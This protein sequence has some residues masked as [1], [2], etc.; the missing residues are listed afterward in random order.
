VGREDALHFAERPRGRSW[1]ERVAAP[2][3]GIGNGWK[4]GTCAEHPELIHLLPKDRRVRLAQ[5]PA[6]CPLGCAFMKDRVVG[7]LPVHLGRTLRAAEMRGDRVVL[8]FADQTGKRHMMRAD[9]VVFATGYR[10]DLGS[11]G[12]LKPDLV[13]QMRLVDQSP[14]LSRNYESSLP[15]L[16]FIGPAATNSFGPVSRF[17]YGTAH[18]ARHLAR[19]LAAILPRR[20][21]STAPAHPVQIGPS[22][23]LV[24]ER[25]QSEVLS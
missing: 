23:A 14:E 20:G 2:A 3:S 7:K 16:H 11:L 12:F 17:L 24:P 9:H 10:T 13:R 8:D 5:M 22:P 25:Q 19:H 21:R 4:L 18:S 15:G 1:F 6:L